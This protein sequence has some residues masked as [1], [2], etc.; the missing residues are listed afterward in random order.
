M[1]APPRQN[2]FV[3]QRPLPRRSPANL[4][5]DRD[6]IT[7]PRQLSPLLETS[8]PSALLQENVV[9]SD[10]SRIRVFQRGAENKQ[11][12]GDRCPQPPPAVLDDAK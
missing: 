8:V 11:R 5:A 2:T 12:G 3:F 1:P 9:A 7:A 6:D 10:S 4:G